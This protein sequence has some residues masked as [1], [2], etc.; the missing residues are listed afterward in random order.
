MPAPLAGKLIRALAATVVAI[1]LAV[2]SPALAGGDNSTVDG[3]VTADRA[4]IVA[5]QEQKSQKEPDVRADYVIVVGVPGL[6]WEDL[7]ERRTPTLWHLAE[8]GSI[9]SMSVRSAVTPTCPAD[10]WTTLSAGN[11][12]HRSQSANPPKVTDQCPVPDEVVTP[13][14]AEGAAL[15]A[16]EQRLIIFNNAKGPWGAVPSALPNSVRCTS[17]IGIGGAITTVRPYDR[18]DNYAPAIPADPAAVAKL[19][20]KCVLTVVD[21]GAVDKRLPDDRKDQAAQADGRLAQLLEGRPENATV[22]VAGISDT[23]VDQRLHVA[24]VDG[25]G[26]ADGWLTSAGTGR[27]GYIQLIDLA[28]TILHI[29]GRPAP[30]KLFRG[31]PALPAQGRPADLTAAIGVPAGADEQATA[32]RGVAGWFFGILAFLQLVLYTL[33]AWLMRRSFTRAGRSAGPVG[34]AWVRRWIDL[35]RRAGPPA[36][37]TAAELALVATA[38][39]IPAALAAGLAPWWRAEHPGWLFWTLTLAIAVVST[40]VVAMV[41]IYRRTLGP[42]G[43]VAALAALAVGVDLATG[44]NL[45]LNGVAGYSA[46]EGG[47]YAGLG[48]VGLGVFISGVLLAAGCLAQIAPRK[49]RPW[50]MGGIGA[51]A[52]VM[53]GD[54]FV[55]ADAGG[56]IAVTAGVCVAVAICTG[57]WLTFTRVVWATVAGVGVTLLFAAI[58]LNR[59]AAE[60]GSLGRF[61]SQLA[62]GTGGMT[63]HRLSESNITAFARTPLTLLALGAAIFVWSALL[64]P[65]GG[66]KRLFGVYPAVRAAVTGI[67]LAT[68]LAGIFGGAALNVAGAAA[69]TVVPLLAL[70]ALRV[71]EH[72]D[73]RTIAAEQEAFSVS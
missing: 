41:P 29:L 39:S 45:Q 33:L 62:D 14:G 65:W 55:G 28:P 44:A 12:A 73:D 7:D 58:D 1:T 53:V 70:G 8:Q 61:L 5:A 3:P 26:W 59:P 20:S 17:A 40:A 10:G 6:R 37:K 15:P 50:L 71:R 2:P 22:M 66:L 16:D 36:W 69:A 64:Q 21:L 23:S 72:A 34:P 32:Q 19:L 49:W 54:P 51:V 18:V 43:M 13:K 46:L 67:T 30:E 60:R 4:G 56:A 38:V 9:G 48:V 24:I 63:M 31:S 27:N 68:I 11:Y 25:P 35:T 52:I 42:A 57:G 47:R